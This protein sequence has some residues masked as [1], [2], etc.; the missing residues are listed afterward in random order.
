MATETQRAGH[1]VV[2]VLVVDKDPYDL[3]ALGSGLRAP[4]LTVA[5]ATDGPQALAVARADLPD[6]VVTASSLGQMG[7][8][9]LS[10]ELKTLAAAGALPEPKILILLERDHDAWLAAWSRCDAWRTKPI[11]PQDVEQLIR[12]LVPGD[13]SG[14][15]FDEADPVESAPA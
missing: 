11:A 10:R 2:L 3:D 9:A 7:G 12:E 15:G 4:D 5:T 14:F 6:V 1:L 13:Q 8:F